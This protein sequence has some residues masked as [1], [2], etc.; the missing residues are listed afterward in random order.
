MVRKFKILFNIKR[1]LLKTKNANNAP[2]NRIIFL[3]VYELYTW[4]RDLN[5]G[6][7]LKDC[8]F[9]GVKIAKNADLDKYLYSGYGFG[10][11]LCSEFSLPDGSMV[12]NLIIFEVI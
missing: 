6:F 3:I 1:K 8:L 9:G 4:S 7:E 5:S 11:D 12:K 10:F 2:P